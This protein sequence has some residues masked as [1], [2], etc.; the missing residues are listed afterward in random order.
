MLVLTRKP[1]EKVFIGGGITV[2][3]VEC[4]RSRV[5]LGIEAPA[6]VVIERDNMRNAMPQSEV[7]VSPLL[8]D[9]ELQELIDLRVEQALQQKNRVR[10]RFPVGGRRAS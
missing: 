2:H 9:R 4:S 8:D 3:L 6:D 7:Q 5:R 1:G 10:G